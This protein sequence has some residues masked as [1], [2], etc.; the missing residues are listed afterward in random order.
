MT[1][2]QRLALSVAATVLAAVFAAALVVSVP[3]QTTGI[4]PVATS[5]A[6]VT[7]GAAVQI[8][9]ANPSRRAFQI[10]AFSQSINFAP[11]NPA[12]MTP[13][14]P[15][16]T[17]GIPIAAGACFVS[18]PVTNSGTSGGVGAA[19]QAIGVSGTAVVT[20]MEY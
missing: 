7:T 8:I 6:G 13:V 20:F 19:F 2:R 5:T 18:A 10:C 3:A 1:F 16:A 12:G 17:V 4:G 15:S 14:V 11:V 9:A